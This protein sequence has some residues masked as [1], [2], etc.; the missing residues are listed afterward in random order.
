[1]I[2]IINF[3]KITYD[4][5]NLG[6]NIINTN[7]FINYIDINDNISNNIDILSNISKLNIIND[8][9]PRGWEYFL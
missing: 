9:N 8:N 6:F 3:T 7:S 1:M 4:I 2:N 5:N